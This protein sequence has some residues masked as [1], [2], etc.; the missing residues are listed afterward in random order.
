[1]KQGVPK[2]STIMITGSIMMSKNKEVK[3]HQ[4]AD[5]L[6]LVL[7][8]HIFELIAILFRLPSNYKISKY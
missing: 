6:L 5:A 2:I 7:K 1:M 4:N 3:I 8:Y